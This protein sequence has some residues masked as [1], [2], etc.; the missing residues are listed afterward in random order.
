[1]RLLQREL[2]LQPRPFE[3]LA[4][5]SSVSGDDLVAAARTMKAQRRIRNV[6]AAVPARKGFTATAMGLWIIPEGRVDECAAQISQNR[7]ASH[8]YL[9]PVYEDWPYNLY[10][11][12]H[13]RSVDECESII[14][15][16]AIDTGLSE[17]RALYPT[18]ELKKTRV[19][20]F[21]PEEADWESGR[22]RDQA[23]A[24]G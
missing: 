7:A 24:A 11:T 15:D 20:F 8:C 13:G 4:R 9:R 14:N 19:T 3:M 23:V 22:G 5:G 6:T 18:R 2:P 16:I 12:V 17:K 1:M 10:T 21:S